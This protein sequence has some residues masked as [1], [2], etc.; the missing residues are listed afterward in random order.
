MN[1]DDGVLNPVLGVFITVGMQWTAGGLVAVISVAN[2][3]G[4]DTTLRMDQQ[5]AKWVA[6]ALV[7]VTEHLVD[8]A[9]D[10]NEDR[11]DP[12]CDV[13]NPR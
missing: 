12:P 2:R 3:D 4:T 13:E 5:T 11:I 9:S 10:K 6:K 8:R 1:R 7:D